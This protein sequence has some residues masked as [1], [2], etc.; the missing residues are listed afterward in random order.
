MALAATVTL[1][2]VDM[3]QAKAGRETAWALADLDLEA[4]EAMVDMVQA[5]GAR[6]AATALADLDLEVG[7]ATVGMNSEVPEG[8]LNPVKAV[9]LAA[10]PVRGMLL[11]AV[12]AEHL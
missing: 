4:Q 11:V 5:K 3:V 1:V 12:E 10:V 6:E 8:L 7:E 2:M 9:L